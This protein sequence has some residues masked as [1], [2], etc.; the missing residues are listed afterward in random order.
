MGVAAGHGKC[1]VLRT[2]EQLQLGQGRLEAMPKEVFR[3]IPLHHLLIRL[4]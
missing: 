2:A 4:G 3:E 1:L